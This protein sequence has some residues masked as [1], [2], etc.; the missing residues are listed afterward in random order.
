MRK[1]LGIDP[2]TAVSGYGI[3][4]LN[5]SKIELIDYG[6]IRTPRSMLLP[7]RYCF[8]FDAILEL[9]ARFDPCEVVV[10]TQYVSK[11]VQSAMKLG[12]ARG[13]IVIA[14]RKQE[15]KVV[16][17]SPTQAKKAL[18]NGQASKSQVQKLVQSLFGLS[19]PPTP[20]DAADAL[21]LALCRAHRIPIEEKLHV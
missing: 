11:N 12:M 18:G 10:E 3:I 21:A 16:E 8:L 9:I 6:C 7:D 19:K 5:G 1:I 15:K 13:A 17:I 20:H 4:Q 2:G 14:A